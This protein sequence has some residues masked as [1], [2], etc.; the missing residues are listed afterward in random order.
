MER[1]FLSE[2]I[3]DEIKNLSP[4]QRNVL[5]LKYIEDLK[6]QEF[7][8]LLDLNVATVKTRIH[9]GKNQLKKKL[10]MNSLW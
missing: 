1:S 6:D 2:L 7:A 9:R 8:D 3:R 4:D 10:Q 5:Y